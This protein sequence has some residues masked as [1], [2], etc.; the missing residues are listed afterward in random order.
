MITLRNAG[1]TR[2]SA[3]SFERTFGNKKKKKNQHPQQPRNFS[4]SLFKG[5]MY[6]LPLKP[7]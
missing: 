2:L 4:N 1:R 7:K 3:L 5:P 6:L